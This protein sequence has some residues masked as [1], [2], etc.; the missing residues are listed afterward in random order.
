[1]DNVKLHPAGSGGDGSSPDVCSPAHRPLLQSL[2]S[3]LAYIDSAYEHQC[4][5]I[6]SNSRDADLRM[7]VL[8]KLKQDHRERREP[9]VQQLRILQQRFQIGLNSNR[10]HLG[11]APCAEVRVPRCREGSPALDQSAA[12]SNPSASRPRVLILQNSLYPDIE[13]TRKIASHGFDIGGPFSKLRQASSWIENELPDAAIL[14][15][16]LPDGVSFDVAR[17]LRLRRIPVIFYTSWK[18]IYPIPIEL[19]DVPFLEKPVHGVLIPKLLSKMMMR[20]Q[21]ASSVA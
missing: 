5:K 16:A 18:E 7:G 20:G 4:E 9:Y 10:S 13:L 8:E 21:V 6:S 19:R 17:E 11:E 3:A 12:M 15:I 1:M 2:L 14:D